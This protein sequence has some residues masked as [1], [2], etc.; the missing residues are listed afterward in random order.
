MTTN[1][2]MIMQRLDLLETRLTPLT[3]SVK[4]FKELKDD[5]TPLVYNATQVL[6][7]ELGDIEASFTLEDLLELIKRMA[8][9]VRSLIFALN[10][11]ESIVDFVKTIEPL[12]R[13]SVP[14]LISY[15]DDLEQR[16]VLRTI[17]ATLDVRAKIAAAY[18]PDDVEQIGD[19]FVA[20]LGL[21]KKMTDPQILAFLEKFAGVPAQIDLTSSKDVGPFGLLWAVSNKEVKEGLGVLMELTKG[22]GKLKNGAVP[23]IAPT[24]GPE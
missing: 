5:L 3:E 18:T 23:E 17:Q 2:E 10:Q 24:K 12:L 13:S 7:K 8:R 15:L 4:S 20:L 6:I 11:L 19:G 16:G 22:L 14:Q 9:S 21:A 1:E